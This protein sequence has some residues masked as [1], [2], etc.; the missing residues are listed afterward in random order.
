MKTQS[1][2][3]LVGK[4]HKQIADI[5]SKLSE[6]QDLYNASLKADVQ[7]AE[8]KTLRIEIK[9]LTR[10]LKQLEAQVVISNHLAEYSN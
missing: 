7:L 10:L 1:N 6:K 8:I 9:N 5:K 3:L 4:L 2:A